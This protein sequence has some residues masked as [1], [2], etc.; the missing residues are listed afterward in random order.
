MNSKFTPLIASIALLAL[1]L[2]TFVYAL[3]SKP[4]TSITLQ[5]FPA[6]FYVAVL[7]IA[8]LSIA[9]MRRH[10]QH[11]RPVAIIHTIS[12]LSVILGVTSFYIFNAPTT[13]NIFGFLTVAGGSIIACLSA[14]PLAVSPEPQ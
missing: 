3:I 12:M 8:A 14:I 1:L 9:A 13:I 5:W 7:L 11:S 6:I 4:S 2:G 10:R